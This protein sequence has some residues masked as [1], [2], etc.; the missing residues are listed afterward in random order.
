[1]LYPGDPAPW[2]SQ[3]ST[4]N[5]RYTFDTVAG[6]YVVLAFLGS[7]G[8]ALAQSCLGAL[9]AN[10]SRF[11]DRKFSFFG[12]S[13]DPEDKAQ[14]RVQQRLPGIRFFWDFDHKVSELYGSSPRYLKEK[15]SANLRRFWVVIDPTLRILDLFPLD[16]FAA[17]F[18]YLDELPDPASFAGVPLQAP[19]LYLPNV[20]EAGFCHALIHLHETNGG[21]FSGAM[22]EIDGKTVEIHNRRHKVRKDYIIEDQTLIEQIRARIRRRVVP[23]IEKVHQFKVTRI[24][25]YLVG[26]YAAEDDAHFNAHRDNTTAGTAHRRFAVSINLNSEFEGGELS[27]PEY[28][29]RTFKPPPG[30]AVVFSCSLLHA[31]SLVTKGRRYAFLP[32]LYDEAAAKLREENLAAGKV[33]CFGC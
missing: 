23:E 27:F 26:C 24:E 13:T 31:V 11:D 30:A 14:T 29:P 9:F 15:Q 17:V 25:R 33:T 3:A 8:D 16:E 6:R 7:A 28:G 10:P 32:F 18:R 2:F 12:V 5:P 19:I 20:F 4:S 1:M 22:R 21:T